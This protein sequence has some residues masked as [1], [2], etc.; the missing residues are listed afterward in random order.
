[1]RAFD[2]PPATI[3]RDTFSRKKVKPLP[4]SVMLNQARSTSV[5][6]P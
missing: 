6:W 1:M 4:V 5:D 3:A 2:A